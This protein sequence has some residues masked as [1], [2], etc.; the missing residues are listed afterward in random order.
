M[1][2]DYPQ[3]WE[4]SHLLKWKQNEVGHICLTVG[5]FR[6]EPCDNWVTKSEQKSSQVIAS[7]WHIAHSITIEKVAANRG[8]VSIINHQWD[9][10]I[11]S[12][13]VTICTWW[14]V[15]T[16]GHN[17]GHCHGWCQY[18]GHPRHYHLSFHRPVMV[19]SKRV[20]D[21]RPFI[22]AQIM[23]CSK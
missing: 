23:S 6:M 10:R 19:R 18:P 15:V 8:S 14:D 7:C 1:V 16:Q 3:S 17:G 9:A 4:L 13:N 2:W 12:S 21:H 20:W 22:R 5:M 11:V